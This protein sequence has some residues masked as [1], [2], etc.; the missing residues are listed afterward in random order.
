MQTPESNGMNGYFYYP[1]AYQSKALITM[2]SPFD[3]RYTCPWVTSVDNTKFL[4]GV[5]SDYG[6]GYPD[7]KVFNILSLG[8]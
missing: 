6:A 2:I 3:N 7:L 1:I 5:S 4:D 8:F